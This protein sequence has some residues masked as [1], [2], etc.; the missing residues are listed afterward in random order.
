[1]ADY[2]RV[3]GKLDYLEETKIQIKEAIKDKGQDILDSDTFRTYVEKIQQI[4]DGG[5]KIFNSIE[6]MQ[7]DPK[8]KEGDLAV[9]YNTL[10][11]DIYF[12]VSFSAMLIPK[13]INISTTSETGRTLIANSTGED[14]GNF[15]CYIP[16]FETGSEQTLNIVLQNSRKRIE[17]YYIPSEDG[18]TY[19]YSY[20][21][22]TIG[23]Q[24]TT[25][26]FDTDD[27]VFDFETSVKIDSVYEPVFDGI[28]KIREIE[29]LGLFQC[30]INNVYEN[31]IYYGNRPS[32]VDNKVQ[33]NIINW[34]DMQYIN[35]NIYML[36]PN[37]SNSS[38]NGIS[39]LEDADNR[40]VTKLD[41]YVNQ[42]KLVF[43]NDKL[44]ILG[45]EP[46]TSQS[47]INEFIQTNTYKL[48]HYDLEAWQCTQEILN[49]T[50]QEV[51]M[52]DQTCY[53]AIGNEIDVESVMTNWTYGAQSGSRNTFVIYNPIYFNDFYTYSTYIFDNAYKDEYVLAPT[54]FTALDNSYIVTDKTALGRNG[55]ITGDGTY[56]NHTTTLEYRNFF[57]P[58]LP[59]TRDNSLYNIILQNGT[60]QPFYTM[61]N[62]K[63]KYFDEPAV[64]STQNA[65]AGKIIDTNS[66]TFTNQ[67]FTTISEKTYHKTFF[68]KNS[69][70]DKIYMGYFGYDMSNKQ[71]GEII[72][73]ES[74]VHETLLNMYGLLLC[75]NDMTIYRTVQ[76]TTA[77][78]PFEGFGN[79]VED[80]N[81][82]I[83]FINY[84]FI[85]D[86]FIILVD[87]GTWGWNGSEAPYIAMMRING[88]TGVATKNSWKIGKN[89]V[90]NQ[91]VNV[92]N[93][94][95]DMT[96]QKLI[97]PLRSW[98]YNGN[99]Q[100]DAITDRIVI[101]DLEG[102]KTLWE[103]QISGMYDCDYLA[104]ENSCYI[105][106]PIYYFRY[107]DNNGTK[108]C[109]IKRI[110]ND[111]QVE[112]V[113]PSYRFTDKQNW[114]IYNNYLFYVVS[115]T[116]GAKIY[117]VD[118]T[119]MTCDLWATMPTNQ[120]YKFIKYNGV[121]YLCGDNKVY[122]IN[123][124][125]NPLFLY[126][127]NAD[128]YN[129]AMVDG[130]TSEDRKM[131]GARPKVSITANGVSY[132]TKVQNIYEF[133]KLN[134]YPFTTQDLCMVYPVINNTTTMGTEY[135]YNSIILKPQTYDGTIN[136][137]DYQKALSTALRIWGKS[138]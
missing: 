78:T 12:G 67:L 39:I 85:N 64:I 102:T 121:V 22:Y 119:N 20:G 116:S 4:T 114:C 18:L 125:I 19:T 14:Y 127:D 122:S 81:A 58:Q 71:S 84:D 27:F 17:L 93:A 13:V 108:H 36:T 109:I 74:I 92:S 50:L 25:F 40:T 11:T 131:Q 65:L 37:N 79:D 33:F 42:N 87:T 31:S 107:I 61:V 21:Y 5:V 24:T 69:D 60:K 57:T 100:I 111:R 135:M 90:P 104:N 112:I 98:N 2:D 77:W 7:Q 15:S 75:L 117:R 123:D 101:M 105:S 44:Y 8:A 43:L 52:N 51:V 46:S 63:E 54:Q 35:N 83:N 99:V 128:M 106:K 34:L 137:F 95:Y 126:Y 136:P 96:T 55:I 97:L 132:S 73:D 28:F 41:L 66:G 47:D 89:N 62:R 113:E 68:V 86:E 45:T 30:T 48:N 138:S 82:N 91:Y 76:Y 59:T 70:N 134:S 38:F 124:F 110:D 103:Q 49:Y 29:F 130:I 23:T 10:F 72:V 53:F 88:S 129:D 1:M 94:R 80:P 118:I 56:L 115:N 32:I 26:E 9:V 3:M 133:E 6:E 120:Q 16:A